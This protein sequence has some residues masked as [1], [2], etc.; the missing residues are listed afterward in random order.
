[1]IVDVRRLLRPAMLWLG[2]LLLLDATAAHCADPIRAVRVW[3]AED[4][5]RVTFETVTPLRHNL[6][7]VRNPGRLV[8]DLEDVDLASVQ[9]NLATKVLPNDPYIANARVGQFKPGIVRV[10]L[11]LKAEVKPQIFALA[12]VGDYGNRLVLDIYPLE[13]VDPLMALLQKPE[14][15]LD[16]SLGTSNQ[17]R[18]PEGLG[19]EAPPAAKQPRSAKGTGPEI[20][21]LVT[22]AIDAG[23]GGEDPG[24]KGR[25]GT[26]EK[27]VT[28]TIARK[29]KALVDS[30]P[31][32]R[33]L[34]TR[35]GDYYIPLGSRVDKATRVRADL[36]V[37]IHA[38]AFTKPHVRGSSVFALSERGATSTTA[39]LLAQQANNADLI[40]GVNLVALKDRYVK[41]TIADLS[42]TAQI[43]DSLK[44][45][46][47]VL[48]EL[49][50]VN[51]LHREDVEQ[52]G[53]A[54]LKA[55]EIPSILVETAFISNP[56]EE[57]RLASEPYQEKIARAIL[58]GVKRYVANNPPLSRPTLAAYP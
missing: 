38:D 42:L 37:S 9:Q 21:R 11:D 25:R 45:G 57:R 54:V 19:R 20:K 27:N 56:E 47:A 44:L 29:L 50:G 10:V 16:T 35:D 18:S 51:T 53:F 17:G 39:K 34:L 3:P 5:T 4:Y 13:P 8:L 40:G 1:V 32:M 33:A 49:G 15:G 41:M 26:Y 43:S 7:L 28:L 24:A 30:E 2:F 12:P 14:L 36:F 52:A 6:L 55:P 58:R 22:I 31:N 48:G 46:R 23:H